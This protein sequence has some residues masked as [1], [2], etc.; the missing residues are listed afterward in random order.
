[1]QLKLGNVR[2]KWTLLTWSG[3]LEIQPIIRPN[4]YL[5]AIIA[6][7]EFAFVQFDYFASTDHQVL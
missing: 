2:G 1:M 5:P 6:F 7:A 4:E 3:P